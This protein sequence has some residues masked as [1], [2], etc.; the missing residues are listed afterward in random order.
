MTGILLLFCEI[1][2]QLPCRKYWRTNENLQSSLTIGKNC[3]Q[4]ASKA[5]RKIKKGSTL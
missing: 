2:L 4:I 1:V 5:Q 3:L